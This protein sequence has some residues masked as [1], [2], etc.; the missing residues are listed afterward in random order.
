M[1][2]IAE[3]AKKQQASLLVVGQETEETSKY[4]GYW[5]DGHECVLEYCLQNASCMTIAVKPNNRKL[6]G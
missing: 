4:G 6:R 5:K 3:E 1:R 2:S